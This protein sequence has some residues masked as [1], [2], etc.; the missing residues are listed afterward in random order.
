ME[1]KKSVYLSL[2]SNIGNRY[3]YIQQA[4]WKIHCQVGK[5]V[6]ISAVYESKA[7]GFDGNLFLNCCARLNTSLNPNELLNQLLEIE[8]Q[9]GRFRK[10]EKGYLNRTIDLDILFYEDKIISTTSLKLPHPKLEQR[11]F[12]LLPLHEIA[13]KKKHP[14]SKK[15]TT[16][17][18]ENCTDTAP[19]N[20]YHKELKNPSIKDFSKFNYIC[21][22]GN[23]GVGKTTLATRIAED[24]GG[25]SILEQPSKNPFLE[26]FYQN[27]SSYAFLT[28]TSFL[29]NR[30]QQSADFIANSNLDKNFTVSDYHIYKSLIFAKITLQDNDFKLYKKLFEIIYKEIKKPDLYIF[31]Q[32]SIEGLLANINKRG[33]NYE[34]NISASYLKEIQEGYLDFIRS[35]RLF[36]VLIIDL[37]GKDF[38][39]NPK[40]YHYIV[41]QILDY[42]NC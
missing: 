3:R 41:N 14:I 23:I 19:L 10:N 17:L 21:I 28:E 5:I 16:E 40:S 33:R 31:L 30:H 22:E 7:W 25:H 26:K 20:L 18:L 11:K 42:P 8:S 39:E 1:S 6:Q 27:Q 37:A 24:Y 15:T 29:V 12:V 4:L 32:Q 36:P 9:L 35:Q 2:G 38:I 13:P 34:Q